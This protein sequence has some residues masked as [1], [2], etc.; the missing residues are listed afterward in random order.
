MYLDYRLVLAAFHKI[1][2]E[3]RRLEKTSEYALK[4]N[5]N[6]TIRSC[7]KQYENLERERVILQQLNYFYGELNDLI[8]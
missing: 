2:K 6:E 4:N 1:E 8:Y 3:Q 7:Q 5:D